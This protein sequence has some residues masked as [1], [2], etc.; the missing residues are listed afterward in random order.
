MLLPTASRWTET[1]C[2]E[3]TS[4]SRLTRVRLSSLISPYWV[5]SAKPLSVSF[6]VTCNWYCTS[7]SNRP[8]SCASN[9]CARLEP[10]GGGT[11]LSVLFG[12]V[13]RVSTAGS[14]NNGNDWP[15]TA[16]QRIF[17]VASANFSSTR[18]FWVTD[19]A[20]GGTWGG[21]AGLEWAVSPF[22]DMAD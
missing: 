9:C 5:G 20:I 11:S 8:L 19:S 10:A 7:T 21:K 2:A 18:M 22:C 17:A 13:A 6:F 14:N 4:T 16:C 1:A 15:L 12:N 3:A